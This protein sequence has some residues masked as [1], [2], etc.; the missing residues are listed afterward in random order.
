M[1]HRLLVPAVLLLFV[2]G[3]AGAQIVPKPLSFTIFGGA[4][5]PTGDAGD[6][7]N[8]GWLGGLAMDM[9][10]PA[11]PLGVRL[12]GSYARYGVQGLSG[13]GIDAHTSDLG[14]NLNLVMSMPTPVVKP[15]LTAG[16]SMSNL[17]VSASDGTNSDSASESHFGFNLGGGVDFGL[18]GLGA[19]VDLRYKR[20]STGDGNSFQSIPLT[21]GIRF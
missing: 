6:A 12:E 9:H 3:S 2:A 21:F 1:R 8:T 7:L 14:V 16:P 13:T 11:M 20:I 10:M 19:R 5:M 18:G 15:Y 4:A 17:K